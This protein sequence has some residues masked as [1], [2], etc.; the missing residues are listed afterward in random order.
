MLLP[1]GGRDRILVTWCP[2]A[3]S[4]TAVML[5]VPRPGKDRGDISGVWALGSLYLAHKHL[6]DSCGAA[7]L[8]NVRKADTMIQG[9]VR[10]ASDN[11]R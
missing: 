3:N 8:E 1:L 10:N 6:P 2:G 7:E 11:L 4:N 9:P 5:C